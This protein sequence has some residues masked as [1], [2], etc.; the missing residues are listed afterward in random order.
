MKSTQG[1][2]LRNGHRGNER[3]SDALR[4]TWLTWRK[5]S[6]KKHRQRGAT[7]RKR[8]CKNFLE[9]VYAH[10]HTSR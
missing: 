5:E 7:S 9:S 3:E 4:A 8:N 1:E 2:T 6:G 10:W